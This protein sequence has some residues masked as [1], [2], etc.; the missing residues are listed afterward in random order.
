[1]AILKPLTRIASVCLIAAP[2]ITAPPTLAHD[3]KTGDLAIDHAHARPNLPNR[4]SAGY[5]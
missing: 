1:M 3:T 2:L 5:L 4:P